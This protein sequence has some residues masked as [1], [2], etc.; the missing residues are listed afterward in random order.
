[1]SSLRDGF[2][3][4]AGRIALLQV[5]A[6]DSE[7]EEILNSNNLEAMLT[8]ENHRQWARVALSQLRAS[9]AGEPETSQDF[10]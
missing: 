9:P 7:M 4:A 6:S 2:L 10:E 5:G 3:D 1:M 8:W